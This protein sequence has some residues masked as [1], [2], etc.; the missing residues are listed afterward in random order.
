MAE[1][2]EVEEADLKEEHIVD[3]RVHFRSYVPKDEKLKKVLLLCRAL[4]RVWWRESSRLEASQLMLPPPDVPDMVNEI[5]ERV[6]DVTMQ[7]L[8]TDILSLAPKKAAWD[9]AR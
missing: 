4:A 2:M 5:A 8:D 6:K 7:S 3:T 9:L 1:P